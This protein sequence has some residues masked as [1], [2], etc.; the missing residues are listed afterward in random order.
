[1]HQKINPSLTLRGGTCPCAP[2]CIRPWVQ[3][4]LRKISFLKNLWH[5]YEVPRWTQL[6]KANKVRHS[7]HFR[8]HRD[9]KIIFPSAYSFTNKPSN[10]L[11][12]VSFFFLR[13]FCLTKAYN[14]CHQVALVDRPMRREVAIRWTNR[15]RAASS[16][17]K[18]HSDWNAQNSPMLPTTIAMSDDV[19]WTWEQSQINP[20]F[21]TNILSGEPF[22]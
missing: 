4:N 19:S 20:L 21:K 7:V 9:A 6:F 14:L 10:N 17:G 1:M 22:L 2:P 8:W 15:K 16:L 3:I 5:F 12:F 18:C 11:L 13:H